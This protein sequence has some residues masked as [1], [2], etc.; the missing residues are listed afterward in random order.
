[1]ATTS[2]KNDNLYKGMAGEY[3]L[4]SLLYRNGVE[5]F[6]P[7]VDLGI[8]VIGTDEIT[9]RQNS[10]SKTGKNYYFQVKTFFLNLQEIDT[11]QE[12]GSGRKRLDYK[13]I[14]SKREYDI[15][16]AL[17]NSAFIFLAYTNAENS[18]FLNSEEAPIF[19]F[20][21]NKEDMKALINGNNA[22]KESPFDKSSFIHLTATITLPRLLS[23]DLDKFCKTDKDIR[24]HDNFSKL[25]PSVFCDS[26]W[27]ISISIDNNR[28]PLYLGIND[29]SEFSNNKYSINS[30][31]ESC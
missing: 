7:P 12:N 29:K 19:L 5:A 1:M 23:Q 10:V 3:F 27:Y 25:T 14:I 13:F 16:Q 28:E 17:D 6:K 22:T 20:W 31:L 9:N 24:P 11:L 15:V 8:D 4:I 30:F 2:N 26:H 18:A 21:A